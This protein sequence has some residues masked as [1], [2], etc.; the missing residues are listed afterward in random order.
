[1][2]GDA[3]QRDWPWLTV[4]AVAFNKLNALQPLLPK[5]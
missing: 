3:L 1:M 5:G 4:L 2:S